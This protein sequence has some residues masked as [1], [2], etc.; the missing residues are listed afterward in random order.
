[1]GRWM[2]GWMGELMVEWHRRDISSPTRLKL[3]NKLFKII[4]Q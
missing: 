4:P 3:T 1:M 2:N